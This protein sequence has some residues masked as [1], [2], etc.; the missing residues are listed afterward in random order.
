MKTPI[1][2]TLEWR[3]ATKQFDAG[4]KV[5]EQDLTELL[6]S[7][8]L[9]PSS[10]GLQPWK[11]VIVENKEIRKKLREAAWNQPQVVDA[12]HLIVLCA[13]TDVDEK[14][15]RSYI[16]SIA[17]QRGVT[18]E[19]LSQFEGM[20]QGFRANLSDDAAISWAKHQVYLASGFLMFT[21][22]QK[23]ID[24]CPMEGFD[25]RK[26]DEILGL[27]EKKLTSAMLCAIGYRSA[28]DKYAQAKKVRFDKKDIFIEA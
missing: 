5:S 16:D 4:K 24:A 22:A 8:R 9:S 21:A 18:P 19:S 11:F 27:P 26:V 6:E 17:Q 20:M 28:D 1:I 10:F 2:Q 3:Y 15:I 23:R 13:R 25:R 12:S 14:Y 7:L